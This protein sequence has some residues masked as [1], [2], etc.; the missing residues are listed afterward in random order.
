MVLTITL[1]PHAT[2]RVVGCPSTRQVW[3][4]ELECDGEVGGDA[5]TTLLDNPAQNDRVVVSRAEDSG[6]S[7][8]EELYWR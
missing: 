1:G 3:H 6:N 5:C 7:V 2:R 8:I 4:V